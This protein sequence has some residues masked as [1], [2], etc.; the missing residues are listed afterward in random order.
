M[1]VEPMEI[2]TAFF[3]QFDGIDIYQEEGKNSFSFEKENIFHFFEPRNRELKFRILGILYNEELNLDLGDAYF[4]INGSPYCCYISSIAHKGE[5][6]P[7]DEVIIII[8]IDTMNLKSNS[9][10][11]LSLFQEYKGEI[12]NPNGSIESRW[13]IL[14]L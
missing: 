13:E 11:F 3:E 1:S 12:F 10:N 8:E 6:R 5:H 4:F 7:N 14:D 2:I 9:F